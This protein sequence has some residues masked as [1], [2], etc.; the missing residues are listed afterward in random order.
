MSASPTAPRRRRRGAWDRFGRIQGGRRLAR[1]TPVGRI[2]DPV[3]FLLECVGFP[4]GTDEAA[5]LARVR[6]EGGG[7]PWR[8]APER[9][10]SAAIGPGLE[11]R[12]D[13]E[14]GQGF[15][16]I[17]PQCRVPHRLRV[18][19][20]AVR[21]RAD[22]PFD[23]LL[24]GWAC[25]P[26]GVDAPRGARAAEAFDDLERGGQPGLYR[27]AAWIHDARRLGQGPYPG[28]VLAVSLAGFALTV[29]AVVPNHEVRDPA[30]LERPAE[31]Y[32]APLGGPDDPGGCCDVSLR[33]RSLRHL[34]NTWTRERVTILECDAPERPLWLCVS[35]WQ[36]TRDGLEL[37]RP[38]LRIEGTFLFSGRL[39]GGVPRPSEAAG[40]H[41]G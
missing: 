26:F 9:H 39:E 4:P 3:D 28:H 5:L 17:L 20:E 41:F 7:A 6:A 30:I 22:S 15:W 33:V 23:A 31:A 16:T 38:G 19:V 27:I 36:L 34:S 40:R 8:G 14:D 1:V 21:R 37:P 35:P 29:E 11:L 2:P 18:A 12:A 24:Q 13:L 32:I 25:P 10:V